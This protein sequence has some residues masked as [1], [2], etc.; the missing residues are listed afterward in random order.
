M[1][2]IGAQKMQPIIRTLFDIFPEAVDVCS[3]AECLIPY[4]TR[5]E[6]TSLSSLE[7]PRGA[8]NPELSLLGTLSLIQHATL[9]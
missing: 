7:E 4:V 3:A 2:R 8:Y 1:N 6:N 9:N 5:D